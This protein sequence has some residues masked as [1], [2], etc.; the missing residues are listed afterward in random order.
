VILM[1]LSSP[2]SREVVRH[3]SGFGVEVHVIELLPRDNPRGYIDYVRDHTRESDGLDRHAA[4]IHRV[5]T[6]R[7]SPLRFV[8]SARALRRIVRETNAD[9]V[10]TLYGGSLAATAYLSGIRPYIVYVVGSD[11]LLATALQKPVARIALTHAA[12]V[13]ANGEHLARSVTTVAPRAKVI[14]LYL[15]VDVGDYSPPRERP[16]RLSFVC[17][18][19]FLEVY[20]N[21]TIVRAL[22]LLTDVP[23]DFTI[24]FL[25]SGPLL[26]ETE[27]LADEVIATTWRDRVIF[28]RGASDQELKSTVKSASFYLSASLSDGTSSSLLEAMA[29]GLIPIV[30]A[31]AANREWVTPDV[32]G[33]LFSPGDHS[34]LAEMI[35]RAIDY[36]P[37]MDNARTENR[38]L[39]E[40]RADANVSMRKLRDILG[41]HRQRESQRAA[42][43][44]L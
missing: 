37:W 2:W 38:R 6:P 26:Q 44:D 14:P 13:L 35:R 23:S 34:A 1:S 21:A 39:V 19:G 12:A 4:S 11:I 7:F 9:L 42:H 33:M 22:G 29:S 20:D 31:I 18:R 15:G 16:R 28:K 32:N 27:R 10:L 40:K 24:S 41:A 36:E 3:L 5:R 30:S 8:S 43:P 25:S 17:T